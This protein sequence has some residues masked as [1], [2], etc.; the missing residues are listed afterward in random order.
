[1]ANRN[2]VVSHV[3]VAIGDVE[4][5]RKNLSAIATSAEN[6]GKAIAAMKKELQNLI[7]ADDVKSIKRAEQLTKEI[8]RQQVALN[9]TRKLMATWEREVDNYVDILQDLSGATVS[10]LN[11]A[12]RDLQAQMKQTLKSS[13]TARW[14]QLNEAYREIMRTMEQLSGKAP[15]LKYV[16]ENVGRVSNQSLE[17]SAA[18]LRQ[19]IQSTD[20]TTSRGRNALKQWNEELKKVQAE[21]A[22]RAQKMLSNKNYYS[23]E[24]I[25]S[26]VAVLQTLQKGLRTGSKEWKSYAES[27]RKAKEHLESYDRAQKEQAEQLQQKQTDSR[28]KSVISSPQT[29]SVAELKEAIAYVEKLRDAQA[30]GSKEWHN[31][32]AQ[33]EQARQYMARF[34]SEQ[35][36]L[37]MEDQLKNVATLSKSALA[38]QKKFWQAAVDG[39]QVGSAELEQYRKNLEKVLSMEQHNQLL[40]IQER[41][42]QAMIASEAG[43]TGSSSD[44]RQRIEDLKQYRD[45][46]NVTIE[47]DE[48]NRANEAI[49][50][51]EQLLR[52]VRETTVDVQRVLANPDFY[53]TKEVEEAIRILEEKGKEIAIGNPDAIRQNREQVDLLRHSLDDARFS[54]QN[55]GRIAE[56]AERG[57]ATISDMERAVRVLNERLANIPSN[58]TQEIE[59]IRRQ[60]DRLNPALAAARNSVANVETVLGNLSSA[61]LNSLREA[62]KAL[63]DQ[64]ENV[65]TNTREFT[66]ASANLDRVRARI[67]DLEGG[68]TKLEKAF[69]RLKNW[70]LVYAGFSEMWN[71]AKQTFSANLSLSDQMSDVR[72]TTGLAADEV[73]R[74]TNEIQAL[75][76]RVTDEKLMNTAAEA[77]RIGLSSREDVLGFVKASAITLTALEEL[78]E[79]AISSVMKLNDLLGETKRLGVEQAILSTASSINELSQASAAAPEPIINFSRRFGGIALQAN[80]STAEVLAMGATL[81]ALAQPIEMSSTAMNKFTTALL[82]NGAVIVKDTGLSEEYYNSMV[83]QGRTVELMIQVLSRL[84]NMGGLKDISKYMKDMGSDGARMTQIISTLAGSLP[85]FQANLDLANSSFGQGVSVI[86]EYNVK[87]ENAAALWERIGN[88]IKEAFVNS[89]AVS[90]ITQMLSLLHNFI[91]WMTS[92]TASAYS[93]NVA[94]TFVLGAV[95]SHFTRAH[96]K[97]KTFFDGL[98]R[99]FSTSARASVMLRNAVNGIGRAFKSLF[100]TNPIGWIMAIVAYLPDLISLFGKTRDSIKGVADIQS[101]IQQ[102]TGDAAVAINRMR[103]ELQ[104]AGTSQ[105]AYAGII[106]KLNL[107]YKDHLGHL[108][109]ETA[110]YKEVA[111]AIDVAAAAQR[112]RII[113]EEQ[114]NVHR[115]VNNRYRTDLH[116]VTTQLY[117]DVVTDQKV[118]T[119]VGEEISR[120]LFQSIISGI[121]QGQEE[122]TI[123]LSSELDKFLMAKAQSMADK[124]LSDPTGRAAGGAS[125]SELVGQ[126]YSMFF[127]RIKGLDSVLKLASLNARKEQEVS[128][129][130]ASTQ[131]ML[132]KAMQEE[133]HARQNE[134]GVIEDSIRITQKAAKDYT[135]ADEEMLSSLLQGAEALMDVLI[136]RRSMSGLADDQVKALDEDI[137]NQ[138]EVIASYK[139]KEREVLLAFT[140]NPLRGYDFKISDNGKLLKKFDE[141]GKVL[142]KSVE[143]MSDA[144]LDMLRQAYLRT[145]ST[146]SKLMS[147]NDGLTD[148]AVRQMASKLSA[149]KTAIK[150][151]LNKNGLLIDE[152]GQLSLRTEDSSKSESNAYEK[153]MQ[154]AYRALLSGVEEFFTKKK[155]IANQQYLDSE[156]THEQHQQR[157]DEIQRQHMLIRSSMQKELVTGQE[158]FDEKAYLGND[159]HVLGN[160]GR[161]KAWMP[162]SE[163]NFQAQ[164]KAD[165]EK[166]LNSMKE[167]A[168]KQKEEIDRILLDN[169]A[170]VKT[171]RSYQEQLEK[172]KLFFINTEGLASDNFK[173]MQQRAAQAMQYLSQAASQTYDGS[174]E[175]FRNILSSFRDVDQTLL[176][177]RQQ[178]GSLLLKGT[179]SQ[180]EAIYA[181]V[182]RYNNA[183]AQQRVQMFEQNQNMLSKYMDQ[184]GVL[185]S[186]GSEMKESDAK[187]KEHERFSPFG[188]ESERKQYKSAMSAELSGLDLEAKIYQRKWQMADEFYRSKIAQEEDYAMRKE[189]VWEREQALNALNEEFQMQQQEH[190]RAA[191]E[192]YMQEYDRRLEKMNEYAERI[193]E[194]AGVMSSANWNSVEDRKRAGEE[195]VRYMA[196]E[197]KRYIIEWVTRSVKQKVLQK[198][199]EKQQQVHQASQT[200]IDQQGLAV[201]TTMTQKAGQAIVMAEAVSQ[202]A[203]EAQNLAHNATTAGQDMIKTQVTKAQGETSA[204]SKILGELGPWGMPLIAV[205]TGLLNMFLSMAMGT[206]SK[207]YGSTKDVTVK[208]NKRLAAGMLTY[209]EGRYPVSGSDGQVYDARYEPVLNTGIYD[210]GN[211]KA[212]FGIFSEKM[213]E[214]VVSGPTT[215]II[216]Q[217]YPQLLKAIMTIDRHG[218]LRDSMPVF[219]S[220]NVDTFSVYGTEG[221]TS[222]QMP[223]SDLV[224]AVREMNEAARILS[225]Q[226][227]QGI[228]ARVN[229][230]GKG[231]LKEGVDKADKFYRKNHL[232]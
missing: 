182:M 41:G 18:Y 98:I 140:E 102:R 54:S 46:L 153:E 43:I 162:S 170:F 79:K 171:S 96:D 213:P 23:E 151:E 85:Q 31:Y 209:A 83:K 76:T 4:L 183:I 179:S 71:R 146:L 145:E 19:L 160:Y 32:N 138:K 149:V 39:A 139:K 219:A 74:L 114:A 59:E 217:D 154:K 129:M 163:H 1:M 178:D 216:Q 109:S 173:G 51:Y 135:R 103:N 180:W 107:S 203:S 58:N 60:L 69:D 177:T 11:R 125:R 97:M 44:V 224:L 89:A 3:R 78:D 115:Q 126:Y 215:R 86:N 161:V 167:Q 144:D 127:K 206:F 196:E 200:L 211:G 94:L 77:G 198:A 45:S 2:D 72:K 53:G 80:I 40:D 70:V 57:A 223:D 49:A 90:A 84:N 150:K 22:S 55:I 24:Q 221:S 188:A 199:M 33:I 119:G 157:M 105:Q 128:A 226:L 52:G 30:L 227:Q 212:H 197:T 169:N 56:D 29:A 12:A 10:D 190:M 28:L 5:T 229:M 6:T 15:N 93:F 205:V 95:V 181:I 165:M 48:I 64:M 110:R 152:K 106:A 231:G 210:G 104:Q 218:R 88:T 220:G 14:K 63:K 47:T 65:A 73:V 61:P 214:M 111:A 121:R 120:E 228:Q 141:E 25:R 62:A 134:A 193:G 185:R 34:Q 27:I 37:A 201:R 132:H 20:R 143:K 202:Q 67:R 189:L 81:D 230:Y 21:Q 124:D 175:T 187:K 191:T 68:A 164:V 232:K 113:E 123:Y 50:R 108:V 207:A 222:A 42:S 118:F 112:R 17:Q 117:Q 82:S 158:S 13:D 100:V 194:F 159:A 176:A 26:S 116:A 208:S 172:L 136:K 155:Q 130:I 166:G 122:G 87:N 66:E 148:S 16:L 137:Q 101:V 174:A 131:S 7:N 36:Q 133:I 156:M 38:E 186:L 9:A 204:I 225:Q 192:L 99:G 75:D 8:N 92:G 35:K 147:D 142:Y 195:M 184:D 91:F 168:V